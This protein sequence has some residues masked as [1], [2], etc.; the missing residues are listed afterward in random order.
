MQMWI[1]QVQA[2]LVVPFVVLQRMKDISGQAHEP[3]VHTL[4][5][6]SGSAASSKF[7]GRMTS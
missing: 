3:V 4:Q 1:E 7:D 5:H 6:V 2:K